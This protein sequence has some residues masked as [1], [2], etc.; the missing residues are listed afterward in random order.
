M[1]DRASAAVEDRRLPAT[2]AKS[3]PQDGHDKRPY[4]TSFVQDPQTIDCA[5]IHHLV[6]ASTLPA[7]GRWL[8]VT[9]GVRPF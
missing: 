8:R 9:E 3:S 1:A 2:D 6:L 5:V 4:G 7:G